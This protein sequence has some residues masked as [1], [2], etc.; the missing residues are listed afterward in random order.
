MSDESAKVDGAVT[1]TPSIELLE[2]VVADML[3]GRNVGPS[4]WERTLRDFRKALDAARRENAWDVMELAFGNIVTASVEMFVRSQLAMRL[5]M[6]FLTQRRGAELFP[7]VRE[8]A[9]RVERIA[10]FMLDSA[11]QFAKVRHVSS[12]AHRR[13]NPKI[14][15]FEEAREKVTREKVEAGGAQ[16]KAEAAEA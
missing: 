12:L 5:R 4:E 13:D 10:R 2:K 3:D 9:A 6:E 8:E 14:L 15:D 11:V 16:E 1:E 7:N